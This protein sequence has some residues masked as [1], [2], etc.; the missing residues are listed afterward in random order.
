MLM[1]CPTDLD[2]SIQSTFL[3]IELIIVIREHLQVVESKLLLY[4]LLE[5]AALL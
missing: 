5:S 4:A 3:L 1:D 2:L